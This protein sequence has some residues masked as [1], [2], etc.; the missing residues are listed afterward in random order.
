MQKILPVLFLELF[1][2]FSPTLIRAQDTMLY[3]NQAFHHFPTEFFPKITSQ[4]TIA[5]S[6]YNFEKYGLPEEIIAGHQSFSAFDEEVFLWN[7]C[8]DD[9]REIITI[10]GKTENRPVPCLPIPEIRTKMYGRGKE[11]PKQYHQTEEFRFKFAFGAIDLPPGIKQRMKFKPRYYLSQRPAGFR[12]QPL[13]L[14]KGFLGEG[15]ANTWS[16]KLSKDKLG[17]F[18]VYDLHIHVVP[19]FEI[20]INDKVYYVEPGKESHYRVTLYPG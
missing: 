9:C 7:D 16:L 13:D 18:Y 15:P 10:D 2:L 4:R 6:Q 5:C 19:S 12:C 1:I 3:F 17:D 20:R 8:A 11:D 14:Y